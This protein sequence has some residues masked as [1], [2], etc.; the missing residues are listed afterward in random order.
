MEIEGRRF[1]ELAI[2]VKLVSE[3]I[4]AAARNLA[5]IRPLETASGT[6]AWQRTM[7]ELLTMNVEIGFIE[8]ILRH[9]AGGDVPALQ[10]THRNGRS[11]T[12]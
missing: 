12:Q 9:A 11:V 7:D 6:G 8:Q 5:A 10:R 1:V 4:V 3:A 2:H